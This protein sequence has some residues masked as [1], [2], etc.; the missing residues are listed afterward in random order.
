MSR[1][2]ISKLVRRINWRRRRQ[3]LRL[4]KLGQARQ[5]QKQTTTQPKKP[6]VLL[7]FLSLSLS[8]RLSRLKNSHPR[9][10]ESPQLAPVVVAKPGALG[11]NVLK[12]D[13]FSW[14]VPTRH[15]F[16]VGQRKGNNL[17]LLIRR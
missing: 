2:I 11:A 14:V 5:N 16:Q 8:L 6:V 3:N 15:L 12:R 7:L 17:H 1:L 13:H 10:Q 4:Q 9:L